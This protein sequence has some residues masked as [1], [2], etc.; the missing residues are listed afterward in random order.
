MAV[1]DDHDSENDSFV[2]DATVQHAQKEDMENT[3]QLST[4]ETAQ[5]TRYSTSGHK[6]SETDSSIH[7]KT[8]DN[9]MDDMSNRLEQVQQ[10]V[11]HEEEKDTEDGYQEWEDRE[12]KI[13]KYKK[14]HSHVEKEDKKKN[15][16]SRSLRGR[17]TGKDDY[18][19][20]LEEEME[21]R[22]T[23]LNQS[24]RKGSYEKEQMSSSYRHRLRSAG[25]SS[26]ENVEL[27]LIPNVLDDAEDVLMEADQGNRDFNTD[28]SI[29]PN[30]GSVDI[31]R[32]RVQT[33]RSGHHIEAVHQHQSRE[34]YEGDRSEQSVEGLNEKSSSMEH[35]FSDAD[36]PERQNS[37]SE[38]KKTDE[39][40]R[41]LSENRTEGASEEDEV[42]EETAD[43]MD[44]D[45][46]QNHLSQHE[47]SQDETTPSIMIQSTYHDTPIMTRSP[48][49]LRRSLIDTINDK[50]GEEG[51]GNTSVDDIQTPTP[52]PP[53]LKQKKISFSSGTKKKETKKNSGPVHTLRL[54]QGEMEK[55]SKGSVL[56]L[57][58]VLD[59]LEQKLEAARYY[60][61]DLPAIKRKEYQLLSYVRKSITNTIEA[62]QDIRQKRSD[63][64]RARRNI[65]ESR[66]ELSH[67]QQKNI[68][69]SDKLENKENEK[70]YREKLLN[71]WI[72]GF[73]NLMLASHKIKTNP[74]V[75][76]MVAFGYIPKIN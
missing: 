68:R 48:R 41:S 49:K 35:I 69:L 5:R 75:K 3:S 47:N 67:L 25:S 63:I 53:P 55:R 51:N 57:D 61:K 64:I 46:T 29:S 70:K 37:E 54:W 59:D 74:D 14:S 72:T 36:V 58:I 13:D 66:N 65:K 24:D 44:Q 56:D 10:S 45:V 62:V 4:K 26:G 39:R 11:G 12:D 50:D 23:M 42:M 8:I 76:K 31:Q 7:Y 33:S 9:R 73:E 52:I 32:L 15:R 19:E 60:G 43:D 30:K 38:E 18:E 21:T 2:V 40:K 17:S 16:L 34:G 20:E 27:Q 22:D 6:V 28:R 1:K 71:D